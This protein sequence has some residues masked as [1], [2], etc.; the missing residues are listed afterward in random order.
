MTHFW[1]G[2]FAE[3]PIYER[4]THFLTLDWLPETEIPTAFLLWFEV[5]K[6]NHRLKGLQ[7]G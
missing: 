4:E 1:I 6:A 5:G 3:L 2:E 7:C